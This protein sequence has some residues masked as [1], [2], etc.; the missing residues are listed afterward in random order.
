M[1]D[2]GYPL[3]TEPNALKS[4]ILPP[5][6]ISRISAAATGV[7]SHVSDV[8]PDATVSNMP[9]RK[10][11]V[12]YA[13]NEI[14]IDV[15]EEVDA[16]V[17]RS[18]TIITSEV[19]GSI[20]ANSRLSGV[21]DLTLTFVDPSLI[22]DCSFHPCVRYA[23]YERDK[24][25]S[26]VPPDGIFELMKYRLLSSAPIAAPVYCQPQVH[27]DFAANQ[28]SV[29]VIV[30]ARSQNSLTFPSSKSLLQVAGNLLFN[31]LRSSIVKVMYCRWRM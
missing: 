6:V 19:S 31:I 22:D 11:D 27:F 1:M 24:V 10:T 14:Y 5:T 15:I 9:W 2:F 30:G 13:Q 16:I 12:N 29:S 3:T 23:R 20:I 8:L 25:V 21:P 18:G 17:S 28:G 4:M 26:F 7:S